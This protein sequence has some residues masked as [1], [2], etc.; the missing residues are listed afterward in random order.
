[1]EPKFSVL[2]VCLN[3]GDKLKV[4]LESIRGQTFGDYEVIIKD[5]ISSDGSRI[6]AEEMKN[7]ISSLRFIEKKD[8]GIYDAMNQAV[9]QAGG[10]YVYFLNCGDVFYDEKVLENMSRVIDSNP[11]GYGIYYGNIYERAT[12]REVASNPSMDAFGCYRNVPCHQAC[13]YDRRLLTAHPFEVKYRVRADYEQFLWCFFTNELPQRVSFIYND[14]II[15]DYE[16]GGYSETKKNKRVSTKEHQEI[17][18]KYMPAKQVWQYR[19]I[20]WVSLA[21]LRTWLARNPL[22]AGCYNKLKKIYY[23]KG[24]GVK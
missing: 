23:E 15:A 1:M 21:P 20:M 22:T 14:M 13:F 19:I 2:V 17:V 11:A 18:R 4:T 24:Q 10:K 3:P 12:G 16:G 5:G 8:T 6:F 7:E 9:A